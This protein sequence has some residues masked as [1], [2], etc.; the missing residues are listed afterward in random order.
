[1]KENLLIIY[2]F[3]KTKLRSSYANN[4]MCFKKYLKKVNVFYC[5][6]DLQNEKSLNFFDKIP[7]DYIL[8]DNSILY[9]RDAS[10][11]EW[12]R[13]LDKFSKKRGIWQNAVKGILPQDE[14]RGVERIREF[15]QVAG[16][17][18][19]YTL[20][21]K[22]ARDI[23]YPK[24]QLH[25]KKIY[26]IFPGY[27]DEADQKYCAKKLKKNKFHN[28]QYDIGYRARKPTYAL[29]D[30]G[31]LKTAIPEVFQ[32]KAEQNGLNANIGNTDGRGA[33]NTFY[34]RKWFDFLFDCRVVPGSLSGAS[35]MDVDGMLAKKVDYYLRQD[36]K[37]SYELFKKDFLWLLEGNAVYDPPSPRIFEAAM[38][39]ACQVLVEG[40]YRIM[41]PGIDYIELK[42]DFSNIDDVFEKIQD[43]DY[44]EAI[45]EN[46]YRHLVAS[47]KYTYRIFV[48]NVYR[49]LS[50]VKH[51][52]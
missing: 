32:M 17:D 25:Y 18:V 14:Y 40:N 44:C 6:F 8:F 5:C 27:I 24:E 39:K 4:L 20:A 50:R 26:T 11:E 1:M 51:G 12:E 21:G 30:L 41:K 48:N 22:K 16:I 34:G 47:N 42:S 19:I 43:K 13:F 2:A 46:A 33:K 31:F 23:F 45:A 36:P 3:R 10:K 37:R 7:F 15:V 29:G 49:S 28:R 35:I 52:N 9:Y 38:T